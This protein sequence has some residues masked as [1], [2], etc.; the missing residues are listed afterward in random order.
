MIL[1]QLLKLRIVGEYSGGRD[2][3]VRTQAQEPRRTSDGIPWIVYFFWVYRFH[4]LKLSGMYAQGSTLVF[5]LLYSLA[6][7]LDSPRS[8]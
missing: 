3:Q 1:Q 5:G 7:H 4:L 6:S 8:P 2:N